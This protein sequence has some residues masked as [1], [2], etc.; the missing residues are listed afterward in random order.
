[1]NE[2]IELTIC[3]AAQLLAARAISSR[4]L[5]EAVL[6]RIEETDTIIHAYARVLVEDA[7]KAAIQAD[8]EIAHGFYRGPLHGIPI[9]IKD[10]IFTRGIPTEVGSQ[11]MAGFIPDQDASVVCSLK[12]AG[13]ILIGKTV[14]HEFAVGVNEPPTRNP[15]NLACYP[16]GSSAG[17]GVSVAVRS[18]FGS[19][20]SD[21]GGSI[22]I[23]AAMVGIVGLKPTYGRVSGRGVVPLA[24]SLD[25]VGPLARTVEDCAI[26]FQAIAGYDPLDPTSIDQA[27]LDYRAELKEGIQERRIGVERTYFFYDGVIPDV[28]EA[29]ERVIAE[30]EG[31]GATIVEV[32]I[33]ELIFTVEA[34]LTIMLS[35]AGTYHQ[36]MLKE[37]ASKYDPATRSFLE[38]GQLVPATHYLKAQQARSLFRSAMEKVFNAYRLDAM[39]WPT[40]PLPTVPLNELATERQDKP[41][42]TPMQSYI[43]HTF[44]ANLTGQPAISIPCGLTGSGL[45]IGFQLIGWPFGEAML[46]R[47]AQSYEQAHSWPKNKPSVF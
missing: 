27:V 39:L 34:L 23:P 6:A 3:E 19:I 12:D 47:L 22:R 13:A 25:H 37:H 36:K 35:E 15:Y 29:V 16:G 33:P 42:E 38:L 2:L 5:V 26:L 28:R 32:T 1:M 20:G 18:A 46:F 4:E 17:S 9:A 43:H 41:G 14:C 30:Y 31:Q 10:N 40:I 7:R 8:Q 44:S 21:T 11:V 45:P 24:W